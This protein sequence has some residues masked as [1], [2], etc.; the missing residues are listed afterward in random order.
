MIERKALILGG[1]GLIGGRLLELLLDDAGYSEV[2]APGRR[3]IGRSHPKL[4][5]VVVDFEKLAQ[6]DFAVDDVFCCL[7]TTIKKAGSPE[8]FRKVDCEYPLAAAR[9]A[10][11]AG[12]RRFLV[13]TAVGANAKS[14]MLYYRVK[15]ELERE[16][17]GLPFPDG[18]TIVRPSML[19]GKRG[20]SRPGEAVGAAVVDSL[21]FFLVG[22]LQRY[23]AIEASAVARALLRAARESH[24]GVTVFEGDRLFALAG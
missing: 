19:L 15:G 21:R 13:V 22:P 3:R 7:G 23:R 6:E 20:E 17:R 18:V 16:L 24:P 4:R 2:R 11:A 1:T 5:E 9:A 12:A 14:G 8:A 10:L